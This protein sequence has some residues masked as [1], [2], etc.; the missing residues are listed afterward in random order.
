M[1]EVMM[2]MKKLEIKSLMD[3]ANQMNFL[4]SQKIKDYDKIKSLSQFRW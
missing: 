3:A 4:N 2:T 1:M